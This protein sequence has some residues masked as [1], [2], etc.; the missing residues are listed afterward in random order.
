MMS[1]DDLEIAYTALSEALGRV[2]TEQSGL[3]LATLSLALLARENDVE[4]ALVLIAQAEQLAQ[5]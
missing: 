4:Q 1:S 3:L 5:T 2:S